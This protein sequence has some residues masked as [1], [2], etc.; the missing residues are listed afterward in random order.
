MRIEIVGQ[1]ENPI[2]KRREISANIDYEGKATPSKAEIQAML[3]K[4]LGANEELVE[5]ST[6]L[7]AVGRS[8]GSLHAK[9]WETKPPEKKK[10]TKEAAPA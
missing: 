10:K 1:K 5:I 6:V 3:A 2:L 4:Q 8:V 7:S 9:V